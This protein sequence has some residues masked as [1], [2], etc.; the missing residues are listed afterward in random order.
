M[1]SPAPGVVTAIPNQ[2]NLNSTAY[3]PALGGGGGG[4]GG[5]NTYPFISSIGADAGVNYTSSLVF[6]YTAQSTGQP[7]T[8]TIRFLSSHNY[9]LTFQYHAASTGDFTNNDVVIAGSGLAITGGKWYSQQAQY[10]GQNTDDG[11]D[12]T[13]SLNI[14]PSATFSTSIGLSCLSPYNPSSVTT[15]I[16]PGL[17]NGYNI[18]LTDFGPRSS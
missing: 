11:G 15:T 13:A 6:T 2:T 12:F 7:L 17:G 10:T 4:G 3:F 9:N 14:Q 18:L 5:S 8:D 1:A 16:T